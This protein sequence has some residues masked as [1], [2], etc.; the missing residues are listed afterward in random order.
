[1]LKTKNPRYMTARPADET[2]ASKHL[3]EDFVRQVGAYARRVNITY[4]NVPME[5]RFESRR[6]KQDVATSAWYNRNTTYTG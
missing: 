2:T 5:E 4:R 3:W 6:T 1:M